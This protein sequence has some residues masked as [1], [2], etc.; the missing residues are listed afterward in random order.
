MVFGICCG[1]K[2]NIVGLKAQLRKTIRE[3]DQLIDNYLIQEYNPFELLCD[4]EEKVF[5]CD[6]LIME[7]KFVNIQFDGIS[8]AAIVNAVYPRCRIIYISEEDT[9][10]EKVYETKHTYLV[11]KE[12]LDQT[13]CRAVRKAITEFTEIGRTNE[14]VEI[15]DARHRFYVEKNDIIYVERERRKLKVI[16]KTKCYYQ[17][18]SLSWYEALD[19]MRRIHVGYVVN[20]NHITGF[21]HNCIEVGDSIWLP[22]GREYKKKVKSHIL[23]VYWERLKT[24]CSFDV[25]YGKKD[26]I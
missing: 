20:M 3:T 17:Y 18:Q 4:I 12:N 13:L 26:N 19:N 1:E 6:I 11:L 9:N 5:I 21:G 22:I 8:L 25:E 10:M 2:N 24:T 23:G 7:I 16:T 14:I 15:I